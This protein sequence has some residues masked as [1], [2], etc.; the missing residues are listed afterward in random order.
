MAINAKKSQIVH[1]RNVQKPLCTTSLYC[2]GQELKYVPDYKY[3]GFIINQHL[4]PKT[5]VD[6]LTSAASR[7][8][9]RIVTIFKKMGNMGYKS[10]LTLF[11]TYVLPIMNYAAGVWGYAE[12]NEPQVLLNRILRFYLGVNKFT[13]N[14]AVKLEM[15]IMDVK[16]YRWIELVRIKNR[17]CDMDEG[18]L[19][20]RVLKWEKSLKIDGW[21]RQVESILHY[22]N[23]EECIPLHVHCDLDVLEA[24][25]HRLSR[26]KWWVESSSM[27]KL[28]T[29]I[30]VHDITESKALVLKNLTRNHRSLISKL[31]CGVLPLGIEIGRHKDVA[32][33]DRL[34]YACDMGFLE[35]E[36]HMLFS[37]PAYAEVRQEFEGKVVLPRAL[38]EIPLEH[39]FME[40][41]R[42]ENLKNLGQFVERLW[43]VR[44]DILYHN[45]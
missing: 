43:E 8:F 1:V 29:F 21:V 33:E 19:P 39:I 24:R 27:P 35:N 11:K 16:M 42:S 38:E 44:R 10:Y 6:T 30:E 31:K 41:L 20:V 34:C 25:L 28:R 18:R 15:D 14:P 7:S 32:L 12:Q 13:P 4:S 2:G 36:I 23:M 5:T 22:A 37:C 40:N 9:G 3:L 17:L 26:E 45:E